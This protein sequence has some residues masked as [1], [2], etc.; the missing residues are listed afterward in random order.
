MESK[1]LS[2]SK[3]SPEAAAATR[4]QC[5]LFDADGSDRDVEIEELASLSPADTQLLWVDACGL[6]PD[7]LRELAATLGFPEAV[8]DSLASETTDL[9]LR[10]HG[11]YFELRVFAVTRGDALRYTGEILAIAAGAN[12]VL[13]VHAVEMP[14]LGALRQRERGDTQLGLLDATTFVTA[15]LDWQLGTYFDAVDAFEKVADKLESSILED[16]HPQLVDLRDMRNSATKLRSLLAP[17]RRV[18]AAL[19]RPDF[20]PEDE[21]AEAQF[22]VL[23]A[24]F[25][26]AMDRVDH[27]RDLVVGSFEMF[28]SRM[29]LRTNETMRTLT[30]ATVVIGGLAVLAGVF[31]MNFH[32]PFFDTGAEGFWLAIAGMSALL[33]AAVLVWKLGRWP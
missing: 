17:H 26:R 31:G 7:A 1:V 10:N 3:E 23:H 29:A 8:R 21:A 27:A 30:F 12:R 25:E 14:F 22:A 20:R 13:T 4:I 24:Q 18:F 2:P 33:V 16:R 32:A 11:A 28:S 9:R 15:L 5:V 19:R 6:E